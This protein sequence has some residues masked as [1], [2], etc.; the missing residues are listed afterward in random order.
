MANFN[1]TVGTSVVKAL[2]PDP[3][4]VSISLN[5]DSTGST[6]RMLDHTTQ[7]ASEGFRL[8]AGQSYNLNN[9]LDSPDSIKRSLYLICASG[10]NDVTITTTRNQLRNY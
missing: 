1:V 5:T 8:P 4:R 9:I 3:E 2:H 10:S 7:K 6:V